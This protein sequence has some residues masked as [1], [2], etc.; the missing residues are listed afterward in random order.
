M[1]AAINMGYT[2]ICLR[3]ISI[4]MRAMAMAQATNHQGVSGSA[5]ALD[6]DEVVFEEEQW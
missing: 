1:T 3:A 2:R 6:Y 5:N 4:S